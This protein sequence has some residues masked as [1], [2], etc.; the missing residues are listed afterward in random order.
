[1]YGINLAS[2]PVKIILDNSINDDMILT[3]V[4]SGVTYP[5]TLRFSIVD[6]DN[7]VMNLLNSDQIKIVAST[8][9]RK[10]KALIY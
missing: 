9:G 2:Y 7:Q 4:V 3:D 10:S 6:F 1:M 5:D 8:S